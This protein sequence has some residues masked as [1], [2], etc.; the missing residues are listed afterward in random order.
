MAKNT[1]NTEEINQLLSSKKKG[2]LRKVVKIIASNG[3]AD[4]N[5]NLFNILSDYVSDE[6]M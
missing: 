6:K 3:L 5:D 4:F 2:D 1:I